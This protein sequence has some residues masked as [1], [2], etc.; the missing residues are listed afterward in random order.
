MIPTTFSSFREIWSVDFEFNAPDGELP[1]IRCMVA[2]ELHSGRT[3]RYW[4]EELRHFTR[5]PFSTSAEAL[6]IAY[7][8]SAEISCFLELGWPMPVYLLDLYPEFLNITNGLRGPGFSTSLLAALRYYGQEAM[9]AEEKER[10]RALACRGGTYSLKEKRALLDY[11]QTDVEAT[12]RLF[13]CMA[14]RLHVPYALNRSRYQ[15]AVAAMERAGIPLDVPLLEQ[16]KDKWHAVKQLLIPQYDRDNI[17]EGET[18]KTARWVQWVAAH[19]IPWP[20]LESGALALD[21]DTFKLMAESYPVVEPYHRIRTLVAQLK[22]NDL[23]VGCDGR[24]RS[25]LFPFRAATGRNTPS[26]SKFIF[27]LPAWLRGLIRPNPGRVLV[28]LDWNAQEFA[29]SAYLSEDQAK[30]AAYESG[31][32]YLRYAQQ[33]GALPETATKKSHPEPRDKYKRFILATD[34]GQE[35][36]S[37]ARR[38]KISKPEA[39][40]LLS[41]YRRTYRTF[42][43][44][45]LLVEARGRCFGSLVTGF[46][47]S[48]K[49]SPAKPLNP[50][51]LRNYPMQASGAEMLQIAC[52][53]AVL[54]GLTVCCPVHDAL[55]IETTVE[56][57]AFDTALA[58][59]AM[60]EASRIVLGGHEVRVEDYPI[61]YPQRFVDARGTAMWN[62]VMGLLAQC[63]PQIA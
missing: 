11:C 32:P 15:V 1:E 27:S 12:A 50:R 23:Q 21:H 47:W 34:Y 8:A 38:L 36:A 53:L 10:M 62:T 2:Q 6:M 5:A 37:L 3:L 51:A 49:I 56:R 18:F 60:L 25:T 40:H 45:S 59:E 28:Y 42:W 52:A 61:I 39:E 58:K 4:V 24:N 30:I 29:I 57:L 44:W 46:G 16:L 33:I 31:D 14:P 63:T 35:A 22:L 17:F 13:A 19:Q 48:W 9:E 41:Q 43:D 7:S 55:M 54:R 26:A 20:R